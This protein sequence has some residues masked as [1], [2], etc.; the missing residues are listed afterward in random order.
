MG[1][2]NKK[3]P[4]TMLDLIPDDV[5]TTHIVP[6]LDE[7]ATLKARIAELEAEAEASKKRSREQKEQ[8]RDRWVRRESRF[9]ASVERSQEETR[10][11]RKKH[12]GLQS[13]LNHGYDKVATLKARVAELE[14]ETEDFKIRISHLLNICHQ[15]INAL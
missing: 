6:C 5:I 8:E 12:A 4:R 15:Y 1:L 11:W 13:W 9:V 7:V 14:A 3:R 10:K 2:P